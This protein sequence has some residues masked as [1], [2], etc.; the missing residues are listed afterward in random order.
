MRNMN[1]GNVQR[2]IEE[3]GRGDLLSVAANAHLENC[4]ACET[5]SRQQSKLQALVSS[6][7]TVEAP[8]DFDFRLRARLAGERNG[9]SRPFPRGD[10]SF[11]FRSAAIA[12]ILVAIGAAFAVVSFRTRPEQPVAAKPEQRPSV[13]DARAGSGAVAVNPASVAPKQTVQKSVENASGSR[14]GETPKRRVLRDELAVTRGNSR[15][16][17]REMDTIPA[18]VIRP[19]DEALGSYPTAAFPINASSQSL[20]MSVDDARGTSRTISLPTVSF[21]SQQA[22][23][24]SASPL[25][26]SARGDW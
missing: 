6:L 10:F 14:D 16:G 9:T 1:C 19:N 17:I 3:V 8:S 20:K 26:A 13:V 25:M 18:K 7:G 4:V 15:D 11:G 12:M 5:L 22:L 23:S 2:E 24:Q 21:G